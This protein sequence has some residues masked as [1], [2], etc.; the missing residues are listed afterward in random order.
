[1]NT[2][3]LFPGQGSQQV[4]MLHDLPENPATC[5]VLQEMSDL[6]GFDILTLDSPRAL[7]S[8]VA[9]QLA[10]L[11]SGVSMALTLR[12]RGVVPTAVIG[13][14][15]G[16]FAAAVIAEV[17]SLRDATVLV[18]SRSEQMERL[19]PN[20][21]GMAAVVG[22]SETQVRQIVSEVHSTAAPVYVANI[23]APR[24]IV[25]SGAVSGIEPVLQRRL[26]QRAQKAE[27][28]DV[29][30]PSHCPLMEPIAQSLQQQIVLL[31]LRPP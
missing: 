17:I 19:F 22:L 29:A 18:R 2:A 24:Q 10:L 15:V 31:E 20:G 8:T 3:F 25:I 6:L 16:S 28:L 12:D 30:V 1:M 21:Y 13:M 4:G 11:A 26:A 7:Q 23:N 5:R 27:F 14:S 9:V